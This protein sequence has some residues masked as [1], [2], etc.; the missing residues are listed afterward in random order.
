MRM[1]DLFFFEKRKIS[2][3]S[4]PQALVLPEKFREAGYEIIPT[5]E[6]LALV[7]YLISLKAETPIFE[8]PLNPMPK[9]V[10]NNAAQTK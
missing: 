9:P 1:P 5:R 6:A 8:A 2:S 10:T 3:H 4:S 7:E